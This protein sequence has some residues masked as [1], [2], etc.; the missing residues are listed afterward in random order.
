MSKQSEAKERQQYVAKCAPQTCGNCAHLLFEMDFPV[1]MKKQRGVW[2]DRFKL[3]KTNLRC[4]I[5]GFAVKKMGT[6]SEWAGKP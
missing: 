1:W 2:C 6:C 3:E 5:G 4:G